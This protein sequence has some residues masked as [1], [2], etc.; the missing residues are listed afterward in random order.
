MF[1]PSITSEKR[2][3]FRN[4]RYTRPRSWLVES[5]SWMQR[6][7]IGRITH[8]IYKHCVIQHISVILHIHKNYIFY[9]FTA[10]VTELQTR[11]W[12]VVVWSLKTL[13]RHLTGRVEENQSNLKI[14][15][16]RA[17]N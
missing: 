4:V 8:S 17:E 6:P 12:K 5:G 11:I 9:F 16:H 13:L 1:F 15:D 7:G 2:Q 3:S 14:V 10:S